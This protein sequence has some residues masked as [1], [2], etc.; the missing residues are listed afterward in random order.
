MDWWTNVRE[1]DRPPAH[2]SP[3]RPLQPIT[4]Y[5]LPITD[6]QP[7]VPPNSTHLHPGPA[8]STKN[9]ISHFAP[10]PSDPPARTQ[11]KTL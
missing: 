4:D 11:G 3:N 8:K 2:C 1:R 10:H 9:F 6:Y 5:Q 7:Q